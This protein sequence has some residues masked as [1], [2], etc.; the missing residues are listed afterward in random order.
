MTW[1]QAESKTASPPPQ[2]P[3]VDR[4]EGPSSPAYYP[5]PDA[6]KYKSGDTS[7]W[8]EDPHSPMSPESPPPA[9][10]G[11]LTTEKLTHPGTSEFSKDP[12]SPEEA[13]ADG[14]GGGKK[15]ASLKEMAEQRATL[16]VRIASAML[17]DADAVA[18]ENKALELMDLDD[19]QLQATANT[20]KVLAGE[21]ED[22]EVEEE[23]EVEGGK[24]AN[25]EVTARLDKIERSM[26]KLVKAMGHFFGMEGDEG[27]SDKELMAYL[28]A[29][30]MDGDGIDQSKNDYPQG[31]DVDKLS[32]EDE[33]ERGEESEGTKEY[34]EAMGDKMSAEDDE[35][36]MLRAMLEEM[37]EEMAI[38][39]SDK[40]GTDKEALESEDNQDPL[41]KGQSIQSGEGGNVNPDK[42]PPTPV[43]AQSDGAEKVG[44]PTPHGEKAAAETN[45][46]DNDIDITAGADPMGLMDEPAVKEASA[47]DELMQLYS[48][49]DLPKV[50][51]KGGEEEE[52]EEEAKEEPADAGAGTDEKA[53]KDDV[54]FGADDEGKEGGKKAA[55]EPDLKP[56]PKAAS[57]GAQKLGNVSGM[58]KAAAD[59]MDQLSKLWDSAPDVSSVFGVPSSS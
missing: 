52:V 11:N 7:S 59:E 41:A 53:E 57:T 35:E 51:K 10:P 39:A 1:K 47:D 20:L 48:D 15:Q 38:T 45:P 19:A 29:E 9:M 34:D 36:S 6:D 14:G 54:E 8:A 13:I 18:I 5:D 32:G 24:K 25:I 27:M 30:D 40:E 44:D 28:T 42:Y 23:I 56:Q 17:K 3:A 4:T 16:C 37:D 26:G 2:I 49:I 58:P 22:E 12:E 33:F 46:A 50:A 43:V 21:E 31:Y 55:D